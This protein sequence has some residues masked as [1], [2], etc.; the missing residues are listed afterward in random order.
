VKLLTQTLRIAST[1]GVSLVA[2]ESNGCPSRLPTVPKLKSLALSTM[3]RDRGFLLEA[4]FGDIFG[5][6]I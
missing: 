1:R 5:Y 4:K 3:S 6:R 2:G